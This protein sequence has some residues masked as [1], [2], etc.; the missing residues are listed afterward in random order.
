[1]RNTNGYVV[2][3]RQLHE[4]TILRFADVIDCETIRRGQIGAQRPMMAG[5]EYCACPRGLLHV[6][7]ILYIH[8]I[9]AR[10]LLKN[11]RV[12]I[13][14]DAAE[15]RRHARFVQNP[16]CD[17]QR[18]LHAAAGDIIGVVLLDNLFVYGHVLLVGE[19]GIVRFH[20][21]PLQVRLVDGRGD[22]QQR[23]ANAQQ[24][25]LPENRNIRIL[26]KRYLELLS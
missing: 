14:A 18:V 20:I 19:D 1:M 10:A 15:E 16:L 6:V 12:F 21:V 2:I 4:F 26:V 11:L 17:A 3:L 9:R 7:L 8:A 22:V 23:V 5:D 13:L 24:Q 25:A